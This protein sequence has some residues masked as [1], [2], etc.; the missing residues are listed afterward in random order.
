[1]AVRVPAIAVGLAACA[2]L[3]GCST[4]TGG[5][6]T[7][8]STASSPPADTASNSTTTKH[9]A[10]RVTTPVDYATTE[11]NPCGAL[12]AAQVTA[13]GLGSL[14]GRDNSSAAAKACLWADESGPS[15][16][17]IGEGFVVGGGGLDG[18][19][20]LR[21]SYRLFEPQAPV[22]GQPALL[23]DLADNR[24]RGECGL[25]VGLTDTMHMLV[26]VQSRTG[27]NPAPRIGEPCA[28]AR[29]VADAMLTT[30]KKGS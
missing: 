16:L 15:G 27:S 13:L 17:S 24:S 19:Y 12:T 11:A 9:G 3:A 25:A 2:V 18:V 28:V 8:T 30:I 20:L 1:M 10:P 4:T 21:S 29:E 6:A 5:T 26:T 14:Q 22:Q 23:I 7:G